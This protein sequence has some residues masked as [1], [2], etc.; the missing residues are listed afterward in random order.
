[1]RDQSEILAAARGSKSVK[2]PADAKA[3]ISIATRYCSI[4]SKSDPSK[5]L[6]PLCPPPPKN[7][8]VVM[9]EALSQQQIQSVGS[10]G[11]LSVVLLSLFYY[12]LLTCNQTAPVSIFLN[13][14]FQSINVLCVSLNK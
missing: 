10:S 2:I 9:L 12:M 1:M 4:K 7:A 6:S 3:A 11:C 5:L 14:N 8:S 13:G